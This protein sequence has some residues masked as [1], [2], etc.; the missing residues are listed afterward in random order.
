MKIRHRRPWPRIDQVALGINRRWQERCTWLARECRR[1]QAGTLSGFVEYVCLATA[2][3]AECRVVLASRVTSHSNDLNA[4]NSKKIGQQPKTRIKKK[5]GPVKVKTHKLESYQSASFGK[6]VAR[7]V[8]LIAMG[9]PEQGRL[10][11]EERSW[12]I[13]PCSR[14]LPGKAKSG[15]SKKKKKTAWWTRHVRKSARDGAFSWQEYIGIVQN[16]NQNIAPSWENASGPIKK[17]S[18]D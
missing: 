9:D 11:I 14:D 5:S 10:P 3:N 15:F 4:N 13:V 12:S 8:T 1:L 16:Q 18:N 17:R 6:L 7:G 2:A